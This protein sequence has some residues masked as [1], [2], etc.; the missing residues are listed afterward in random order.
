MP[1]EGFATVQQ[2]PMR[3]K[4]TNTVSP[5]SEPETVESPADASST[6]AV[7]PVG[8]VTYESLEHLDGPTGAAEQISEP[9][10]V[11]ADWPT[12]EDMKGRVET[13]AAEPTKAPAKKAAK[14]TKKG[15]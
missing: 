11:H 14:A 2:M 12:P 8:E 4:G 7:K 5:R 3:D 15:S 6:G 13:P 10:T 9:Q 1:D